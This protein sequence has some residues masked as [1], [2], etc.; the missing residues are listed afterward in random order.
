MSNHWGRAPQIESLNCA[1]SHDAEL[2]QRLLSPA[3]LRLFTVVS[4]VISIGGTAHAHIAMVSPAPAIIEDG[5]GDPQKSAPCGGEGGTP[6][7]IVTTFAPGQ[8]ITVEWVETVYHPGHFRIAFASDRSQLQDPM[9]TVDANQ[10]SVSATIEDPPVAPVL[11]DNLFPRTGNGTQGTRF[12][13][14]VTLPNLTCDKCTLQ[15][16]QFMA[17]HGPPNYIYHHCADIQL[18]AQATGGTFTDGGCAM[19]PG[20]PTPLAL[21][22]LLMMLLRQRLLS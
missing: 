10:T 13:Q 7:G 22:L 17:G 14:D 9:V 12:R 16:I 15:L 20:T 3:R 18:K 6:S 8:T 5:T 1:R 21:L 19:A 2:V 11:L 4:L